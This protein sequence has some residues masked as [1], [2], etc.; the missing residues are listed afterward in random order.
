V[1]KLRGDLSRFSIT[2]L[3]A[4]DTISPGDYWID[5][6][7]EAMESVDAIIIVLSSEGVKSSSLN[8]EIAFALTSKRINGKRPIIPL[9]IDQE[10]K[11][12][13]FLA[14]ISF[15]DFS[16]GESYDQNLR[17]LASA[18]QGAQFRET[19]P[20]SIDRKKRYLQAQRML[21]D[22]ERAMLQDE[23]NKVTKRIALFT[24]IATLVSFTGVS[25][26]V[27]SF[28][29]TVS[30]TILT[31]ASFLAGVLISLLATLFY[32]LRARRSRKESE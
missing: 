23:R 16:Q 25:L 21:L 5:K 18:L 28:S 24:W 9:V 1:Q 2:T 30:N 4:D 8:S 22:V 6:I 3:A 32:D 15:I 7:T 13:P 26:A 27:F 11:V 17:L 19:P 12:P 14:N 20:E 29:A 10:V 31:V